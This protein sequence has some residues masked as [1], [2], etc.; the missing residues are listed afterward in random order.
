VT[1]GEYAAPGTFTG[2]VRGTDALFV[3]I[4]AIRTGPGDLLAA[5]RD[6]GLSKIVL[7]SSTTVRTRA[8][9]CTGAGQRRPGRLLPDDHGLADGHLPARPDRQQ[10]I[11]EWF[12]SFGPMQFAVGGAFGH[13]ARWSHLTV[14]LAWTAAFTTAG[15]PG[16]VRSVIQGRNRT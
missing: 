12:P 15:L 14:G 7:P 11:L 5:A 1:D 4:G 6:A 8:S 2:A 9:R 13:A 3:N 10:A 16:S